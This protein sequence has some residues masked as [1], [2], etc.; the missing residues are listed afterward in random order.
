MWLHC[1]WD[2]HHRLATPAH[3]LGP[4]GT[5]LGNPNWSLLGNRS[6]LFGKARGLQHHQPHDQPAQHCGMKELCGALQIYVYLAP[7]PLEEQRR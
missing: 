6:L 5:L 4:H 7:T 3:R 2:P 1:T